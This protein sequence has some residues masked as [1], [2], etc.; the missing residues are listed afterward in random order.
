MSRIEL[1]PFRSHKLV[2]GRN[3]RSPDVQVKLPA[4][5]Y[6]NKATDENIVVPGA[7]RDP[8]ND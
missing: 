3:L 6:E 4:L 7:K 1:T 8:R 5:D 2:L